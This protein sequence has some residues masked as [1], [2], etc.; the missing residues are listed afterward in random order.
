LVLYAKKKLYR[1]DFLRRRIRC[2]FCLTE[3]HSY[4]VSKTYFGVKSSTD[5]DS[6]CSKWEVG[7]RNVWFCCSLSNT[8]EEDTLGV[9][10]N[11]DSITLVS[12]SIKK[13]ISNE[14]TET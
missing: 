10:I 11:S 5:C 8:D 3:K 12:W 14:I 6:V 13:N 2:E 4:L 7:V 1:G 9:S